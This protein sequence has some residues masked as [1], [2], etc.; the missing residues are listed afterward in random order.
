MFG[1]GAVVFSIA[2]GDFSAITAFLILAVCLITL[3]TDLDLDAFASRKP[4]LLI[5]LISCLFMY[6]IV[7]V[8]MTSLLMWPLIIPT[9]FGL[10]HFKKIRHQYS[11]VYRG[12]PTY[13]G[14]AVIFVCHFILAFGGW[15]A[16][17]LQYFLDYIQDDLRITQ[18]QHPH[19]LVVGS[20]R[21]IATI[22][23]FWKVGR[24]YNEKKPAFNEST[25][26]LF[27]VLHTYIVAVALENL[28]Q[29][30]WVNEKAGPHY[31][32]Y[33]SLGG[34]AILALILMLRFRNQMYARLSD[35]LRVTAKT[36][37]AYELGKW[38]TP[39]TDK[40]MYK[41][42]GKAG[43]TVDKLYRNPTTKALEWRRQLGTFGKVDFFCITSQMP[44]NE[45]GQIHDT[46]S[47]T[48]KKLSLNF[49]QK[50]GHLPTFYIPNGREVDINDVVNPTEMLPMYAAGCKRTLVILDEKIFSQ[51]I[52]VLSLFVAIAMGDE[53]NPSTAKMQ[54]TCMEGF[55]WF[56]SQID[57][58]QHLFNIRSCLKKRDDGTDPH[59]MVYNVFT[60]VVE[61]CG[62]RTFED[63]MME[64]YRVLDIHRSKV[65]TSN[66]GFQFGSLIDDEIIGTYLNKKHNELVLPTELDRGTITQ[67]DQLGKGAFGIVRLGRWT[68]ADGA[69]SNVAVKMPRAGSGHAETTVLLSE[70]LL[71]AQ[72]K[73]ENVLGLVGVVTVDEPMMLVSQYCA[74]GSLERYL[75]TINTS[76]KRYLFLLHSFACG[77]A[78]G[79]KYLSSQQFVHRDLAARNILLSDCNTT[80][81]SDFGTGRTMDTAAYYRS[82][83][84]ETRIPVRW[85]APE[86]LT[87][88]R[89]SELSDVWSFGVLCIEIFTLGSPAPYKCMT[90]ID[91]ME[92]VK[93]GYTLPRPPLCP[94]KFFEKVIKPCFE[95][96]PSNRKNFDHIYMMLSCE[97]LKAVVTKHQPI[98][99]A[100]HAN[101]NANVNASAPDYEDNLNRMIDTVMDDS[102]P[103]SIPVQWRPPTRPPPT[104][105]IVPVTSD[106]PNAP[107]R[108]VAL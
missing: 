95:F 51:Q 36:Y 24:Y 42:L 41:N 80:L 48:L 107:Y 47:S 105:T 8:V 97:R 100:K 83:K 35:M 9:A 67:L 43:L 63:A 49:E 69:M 64:F 103:S 98:A 87:E 16:T 50:H 2:L 73:H 91:V 85:C 76:N 92:K 81:V 58:A 88:L 65:F 10:V 62:Y 57:N 40:R 72:F 30:I 93:A 28:T 90:N 23:S 45:G 19:F 29:G 39:T 101:A 99:N 56:S 102:L 59:G 60:R 22:V 70:A 71:M 32:F 104:P 27:F 25:K 68:D 37:S 94:V 20:I 61:Q 84:L 26:L 79:M 46:L 96:L 55:S 74:N 13:P 3:I 78:C 1:L 31:I 82:T 33:L 86:V 77:V 18:F 7:S 11:P 108:V 34:I 54:L 66:G 6:A 89:Y 52:C 106:D 14:F 53:L 21:L 44:G 5:F 75:R 17:C 15:V 38:F 12:N 4:V